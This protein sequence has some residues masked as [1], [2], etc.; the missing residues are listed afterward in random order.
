MEARLFKGS[1]SLGLG[2]QDLRF[3]QLIRPNALFSW[4][5]SSRGVETWGEALP[6]LGRSVVAIERVIAA[7]GLDLREFYLGDLRDE[8]FAT[9]LGFLEALLIQKTPAENIIPAFIVDPD[10]G[11]DIDD[12]PTKAVIIELP[13]VLNVST[14]GVVVWVRARSAMFL[15]EDG[16][17][18]GLRVQ[19]QLDCKYEIHP[20]FEKSPYPE[21]WVTRSW[22]TIPIT[23]FAGSSTQT[24]RRQDPEKFLVEARVLGLDQDPPTDDSGTNSDAEYPSGPTVSS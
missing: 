10:E 9:S 11:R 16:S 5:G 1:V 17:W 19:E 13:V 20:R 22:P 24:A 3:F 7:I 21:L 12:V 23:G 4:H 14:T 6:R 8:E 18:C 2:A 15:A